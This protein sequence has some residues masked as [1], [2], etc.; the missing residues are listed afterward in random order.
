MAPVRPMLA[1]PLPPG[2]ALPSGPE[3]VHEVKWDGM[4]VLADAGEGSVRLTSRT[5]RDTTVAFPELTGLADLPDVLLDGEVVALDA[6]GRPSFPVLQERLHVRD[7]A[8]A[9]ALAGAVPVAYVVFDVLRLYGADLTRRP[10]EAR[11]AALEQLDLG[12]GRYGPLQVSSWH[13]DGAALL[14]ATAEQG[15]EGVVAKRRSSAYA[16]GRRAPAWVKQ[17]HRL[18]RT[19]VI[20]GW[21][22]EVG[23]T[24]RVGSLLVGAPDATGA[25]RYLGRVGSGVAGA[26]ATD[27][28]RLLGPLRTNASPFAA[29]VPRIDAAGATWVHPTLAVEVR[30]LGWTTGGRLRQPS[31]RGLR[32]DAGPDAVA[33]AAS[34]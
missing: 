15:L 2:G 1:S 27:L 5:E 34:P 6:Q 25:L 32:L 3:W 22:P 9:R 24:S 26:A 33:R 14:A 10:L 18:S 13:D 23:T 8:R 31:Y 7:A 4:R 19:C 12:C 30:H 29:A 20:G 17:A 21:R 16:P 28:G 11:R